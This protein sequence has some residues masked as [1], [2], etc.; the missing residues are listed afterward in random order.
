MRRI[1]LY[2]IVV[3]IIAVVLV[4]FA[5]CCSRNRDNPYEEALITYL[6]AMEEGSQKAIEYT[7]FPN[8]MIEY[9]YLHAPMRIV[10]YEIVSSVRV[11]E[12]LFAFTLNIAS[13]DQ[14]NVYTPLYYFVGYQDREYSEQGHFN[15]YYNIF[16]NSVSRASMLVY[17]VLITAISCLGS[18]FA[19]II[20]YFMG[21]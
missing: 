21:I 13:S 20:T 12:N 15:F 11:N 3:S 1:R 19:N 6:E 8:E 17:L 16:K 14:P 9:D 5:N 4:L 2:L 7:A 10:D 18:F